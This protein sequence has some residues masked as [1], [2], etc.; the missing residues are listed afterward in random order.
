[1]FIDDIKIIELKGSKAIKKIKKELVLAFE[2]VDMGPISF[3]LG[4]KVKRNQKKKT[5]KLS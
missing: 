2:M 5:I 4:L 3:Y 1:M